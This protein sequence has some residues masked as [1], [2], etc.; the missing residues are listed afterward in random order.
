MLAV[1]FGAGSRTAGASTS[2]VQERWTP[3]F[4]GRDLTSWDTFLGKPHKLI[5]VPGQPRNER[6]EYTTPIGVNM[7]PTSVFSVVQ[8]DGSAAIRISG[9]ISEVSTV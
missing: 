1:P 4:N 2:G 9:E 3:L 6:G 7:D 8:I 5:D